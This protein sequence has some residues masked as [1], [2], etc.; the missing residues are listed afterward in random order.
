MYLLQDSAMDHISELLEFDCVA[1]VRTVYLLLEEKDG[2][3]LLDDPLMETA[4]HE[5]LPQGVSPRSA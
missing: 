1:P 3:A 4:T 2:L 5:I